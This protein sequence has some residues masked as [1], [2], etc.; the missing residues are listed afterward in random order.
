MLKQPSGSPASIASS[1]SRSAV[2]GVISDGLSTVVQPAASAGKIF[3]SA[4]ISGK[5]Q[6][7]MPATT[8]TGSCLVQ[9]V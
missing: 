9:A 7:E 8:P 4:I 2:S 1:A 3:Q 5:F 6:G